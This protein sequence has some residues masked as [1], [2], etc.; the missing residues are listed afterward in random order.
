[1]ASLDIAVIGAGISGLAAAALLARDGNNVTIF[2]QFAEPAP[3][4]A[5]LLLQPTGLAC[6]AVLGLDKKAIERGAVIRSLH[7]ETLK[8]SQVFDIA[9]GELGDH[10]FGVGIHRH[11][12]FDL[13]FNSVKK[14]GVPIRTN[15]IAVDAPLEA[16]GKRFIAR[17]AGERAGPFDLVIDASGYNSSLRMRYGAVK[18]NKAYPYGALWG[19]CTYPEGTTLG[20]ANPDVLRQRYDGARLMC[21]LLPVGFAPR[22][23][24]D[25]AAFFW[26]LP[27]ASYNDWRARGMGAWRDQVIGFWPEMEPFVSQFQ[28]QDH[29]TLANY[30]DG[31]L[32]QWH[33]D[34]LAFIGDAAHSSSPQLG[35]GANL[36]LIDAVVLAQCI[37]KAPSVAYALAR[38]SDMRRQHVRFYQ[39]ASRWLTPFFQS[40]SRMAGW[41]RDIGFPLV[42]K[43]PWMRV[44]M[45]E[46]L[47]GVKT[48]IRTSLDPG[49]WD[50]RYRYL[51]R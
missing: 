51:Q 5:G 35:Q 19:I 46:T 43:H 1:M 6:L 45:L 13:L 27:I 16:D 10:L 42:Q 8:G 32:K 41:V 47:A 36:G 21:G 26:S 50:Q 20:E 11:T 3:T 22:K 24:I 18:Q 48:G 31:V 25:H 44:K 28:I 12:L 7:G 29:L 15:F 9:Y 30:G 4:G 23:R 49:S 2:E 14:A 33:S 40:D 34:A 37:N 17:D 39:F 38:Y